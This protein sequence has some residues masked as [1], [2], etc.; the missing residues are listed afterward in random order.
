LKNIDS[1]LDFRTLGIF[2][3]WPKAPYGGLTSADMSIITKLVIQRMA[4]P[5]QVVCYPPDENAE[6]L[7]SNFC[8]FE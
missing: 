4:A 1:Y 3:P 7:D 5:I 6:L 8:I 2:N